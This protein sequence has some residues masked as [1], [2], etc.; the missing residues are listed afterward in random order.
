MVDSWCTDGIFDVYRMFMLWSPYVHLMFI[1]CSSC[2]W[3]VCSPPFYRVVSHVP[4]VSV[5]CSWCICRVLV[6]YSCCIDYILKS[7]S[8]AHAMC[9]LCAPYVYPMFVMFTVNVYVHFTVFA[10]YVYGMFVVDS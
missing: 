10:R 3:R 1:L 4:G 8:H 9:I 6:L 7:L 2:F 5:V